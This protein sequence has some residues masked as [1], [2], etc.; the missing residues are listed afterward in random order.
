MVSILSEY[1]ARMEL[2]FD[3]EN[4]QY[5]KNFNSPT[6]SRKTFSQQQLQLIFKRKKNVS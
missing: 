4:L 6:F 5:G 1:L 3:L 2:V